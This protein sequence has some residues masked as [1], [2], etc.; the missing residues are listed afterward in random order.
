MKN[1]PLARS[2]GF[3]GRSPSM[4]LPPPLFKYTKRV[5]VE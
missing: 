5:H 1:H 2:T 4:I 3:A